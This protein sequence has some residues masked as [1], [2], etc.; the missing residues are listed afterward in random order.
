VTLVTA[1]AV[2]QTWE[3]STT[4]FTGRWFLDRHLQV[5]K[6]GNVSTVQKA[7]P[8]HTRFLRQ[9]AIK[10]PAVFSTVRESNPI[11]NDPVRKAIPW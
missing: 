2:A 10:F 1:L 9:P 3:S 4:P 6:L 8:R 11:T 5:G 7:H